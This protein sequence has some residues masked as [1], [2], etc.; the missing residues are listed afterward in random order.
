MSL[1]RLLREGTREAHVQ[2]ERSP[3]MQRVLRGTVT[4][5]GYADLL[6]GLLQV[7]RA[8]ESELEGAPAAIRA[9][10]PPGLH[11]A[12]ALEKDLAVFASEEP[13]PGWQ[14]SA[15]DG[16]PGPGRDGAAGG[17]S[18]LPAAAGILAGRI[19]QVSGQE[20]GGG[21]LSHAYVRYLGDLSGG[22]V[23]GRLVRKAFGLEGGEGTA[24]YD[25]PDIPDPDAFKDGYRRALD[26]LPLDGEEQEAVV[27]E[28]RRAFALHHDLFRELEEREAARTA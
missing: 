17:P 25:F 19:R 20:N 7:Y 12:P 13:L 22:Q 1:A 16:G 8:L 5:E 10:H 4:R 26:A 15:L 18:S 9:L 6:R 2:A 27:A 3:F 21:L 28:A 24:F 11:R 14:A 23:L